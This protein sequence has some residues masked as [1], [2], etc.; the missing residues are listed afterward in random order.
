M[1]FYI[2]SKAQKSKQNE[3]KKNPNLI[4]SMAKIRAQKKTSSKHEKLTISIYIEIH[5]TSFRSSK[6]E[7]S[8]GN[9][10]EVTQPKFA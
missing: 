8:E 4:S 6:G 10:E 3:G 7:A 2:K 9:E 1:W 5:F